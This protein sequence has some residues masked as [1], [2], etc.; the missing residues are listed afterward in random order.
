MKYLCK[1][2]MS[3]EQQTNKRKRTIIGNHVSCRG[4]NTTNGPAAVSTLVRPKSSS[5]VWVSNIQPRSVLTA[6]IAHAPIVRRRGI[7]ITT[8]NFRDV[9]LFQMRKSWCTNKFLLYW[10]FHGWRVIQGISQQF[11]CLS[12]RQHTSP[13]D[14]HQRLAGGS[15][16]NEKNIS[17]PHLYLQEV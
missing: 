8:F 13:F 9:Y 12:R 7:E 1:R 10:R 5:G 16:I 2:H 6:K 15:K 3:F 11:S 14:G 17:V 4:T